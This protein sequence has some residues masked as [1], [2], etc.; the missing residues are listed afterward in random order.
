MKISIEQ[1]KALQAQLDKLDIHCAACGKDNFTLVDK[2]Y[3]LREFNEGNVII[4]GPDSSVIPLVV[5]VCVDCGAL[6]TL[7]AIKLGLFN[8]GEKKVNSDGKNTA[9]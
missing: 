9:K 4:G 1:Q 2:I 8:V 3:E 7:S 6:V 5:L